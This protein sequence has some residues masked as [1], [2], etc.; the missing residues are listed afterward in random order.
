MKKT[1]GMQVRDKAYQ[2]ALK[3][4]FRMDPEQIHV[5]MN[6]AIGLLHSAGPLNRALNRVWPVNDPVLHQ[7]VFGVSFPRPLGLAAGF[8]KN[9]AAAD[10]WGPIGFGYAELGTVTAEGQP[11]NP[12]P[13]LFR[14]KADKAILNRMGFN[15]EGALNAAENLRKRRYHDPIGINIGK[16]KVTPAEKAID[17]YRRSASVL[18]ELADYLVVN[19]SSPNTPGLRDLQAVESLRPILSA[20]QE[21]TT[22]PVLVKIAPDLSDDDVDAVADLALELNLAGIVATNTTISRENLQ[23]PANEVEAMGAGGVSGPP[24]AARSLEVLR[25][26]HDRVGDQLV[27]I[28][29]GGISTPEQAWERITSGASLLQG[30]TGLI[31]GGPDWIQ[32]I[33][34]GIAAQVRAHGLGNISQAVGSGLEWKKL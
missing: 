17:D 9:A 16:T 1:L 15:N 34:Q 12:T 32:H 29:V 5:V 13:R 23:T 21:C 19:V 30:Y 31:Y 22:R 7:E 4:M 26:L 25:R 11:G 8:D 33:H 24:V 20:V 28:S 27:L 14:L 18:G 10:A 3:G 2:L 6:R